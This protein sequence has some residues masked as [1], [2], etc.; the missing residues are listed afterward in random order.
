MIKLEFRTD[1][2]KFQRMK[3]KVD[4]VSGVQT[5]RLHTFTVSQS[6][7]PLERQNS[8]V[9]TIQL[10]NLRIPEEIAL[11]VRAPLIRTRIR[12]PPHGPRIRRLRRPWRIDDGGCHRRHHGWRIRLTYP[13]SPYHVV[14]DRTPRPLENMISAARDET[15]QPTDQCPKS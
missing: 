14:T 12:K 4:T 13:R 11:A 9:G 3:T 10:P 1:R 8:T 6:L 2:E 7:G 5:C 15:R